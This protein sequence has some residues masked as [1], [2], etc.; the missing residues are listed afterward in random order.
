MVFSKL[1]VPVLVEVLF[2]LNWTTRSEKT[3]VRLVT[4]LVQLP[5]V[6]VVA[7]GLIFQL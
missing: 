7:D 6:P 3:F 2:L 5:A 4:N 1:I